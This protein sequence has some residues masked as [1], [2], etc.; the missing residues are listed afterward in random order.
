MLGGVLLIAGQPWAIGLAA[1]GGLGLILSGLGAAWRQR[2][3]SR[4]SANR[5]LAPR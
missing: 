2:N 4:M 3:P 5:D 1:I